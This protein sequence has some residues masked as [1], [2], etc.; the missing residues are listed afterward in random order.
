MTLL[1]ATGLLAGLP[2]TPV[3][4][5]Q[6]PLAG[7]SA[8]APANTAPR[9]SATTAATA[10]DYS[11]IFSG[12][13]APFSGSGWTTCPAPIEWSV[14]TRGLTQEQAASQIE[15]LSWAF[16][17]WSAAS[18][19][20]FDYAGTEDLRYDD[21]AFTL[22]PADGSAAELRHIYLDF[23]TA[24]ESSRLSGSTVGLG[25]PTQVMASTKTIV[26][27]DAV[28]RSDHVSR[29]TSTQLRSLYLH[30]LGH[31]LGLAHASARANIMYPIVRARV[32]LG[33]GD[34]NGIHE[35]TKPCSE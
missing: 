26:A 27:G 18:G 33:A 8:P 35:M 3:A 22:D 6:T 17:Q 16:A 10:S 24:G 9:S 29:A 15:N 30:E 31:V 5:V 14:D 20:A 7:T 2:A 21:A 11:S 13:L 4:G 25:S 19:L 23:V 12:E 32:S 1:L 34:V 28:F